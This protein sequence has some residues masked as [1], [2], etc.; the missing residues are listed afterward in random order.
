MSF[1]HVFFCFY[2][3]GH[4]QAFFC[5]AG[6]RDALV[7]ELE[8]YAREIGCVGVTIPRNSAVRV[9]LVVDAVPNDAA[10]LSAH[11]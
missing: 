4:C 9:C 7:C 1:K 5:E 8:L 10:V 2:Q 11:Y 6:E 3:F